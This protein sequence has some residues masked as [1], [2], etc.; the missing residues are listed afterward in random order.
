LNQP[1][2]ITGEGL[3]ADSQPKRKMTSKYNPNAN[4]FVPSQ[5]SNTT[6]VSQ[7][8]QQKSNPN[9][10]SHTNPPAAP[11]KN[12]R[13]S[14]KSRGQR[15]RE[16]KTNNINN[17]QSN[18]NFDGQHIGDEFGLNLEDEVMS[19]HFKARGRR[20]QIS[21]NH[22]LDFSLP[23]RDLESDKLN[24]SVPVRRRRRRSDN[25]EKIHLRGEE[26]VNANYR[27]IVDYRHDYKGQT[28]DPNLV[29]SNS[30]ILRVIVPKG[31][32]CPICLTEEIVAPRMIS[33]GHIFCHTCLLS[34][35]DSEGVKKKEFQKY[36]EC[37]L[38]SFSVKPE[39]IKPVLI[40]ET[41]ERFEVPQI[42]QDVVL[43]LMAKPM[44]NILPIP[45]GL[46][47]NHQ[48]IGNMPW[49][50]D[51]ELYPY[52]RIMKGGLKFI[53]NSYE[54]E[55]LAITKQ[56]EEDKLLYNDDGKYVKKALEDI[57]LRLRLYREGFGDNYTEPNPLV[58][59]MDNLS[60]NKN[61]SG[62]SDSNCYFFYQT[63]FNSPTRFFLSSLDVKVLLN[64]YGSYA[65]F[66]TTLLLKVDN[67]SY[68]HMVTENTLKKYKY[69]G[70]L[71]LGTELAFIDVNWTNMLSPEVHK[72]FAK[73]LNER[74]KKILTK[75]KKEDRAKRSFDVEQELKTLD[76][77]KTENDG[78]G[79]YDFTS[80][81]NLPFDE[82]P[83][84]PLGDEELSGEGNDEN[85]SEQSKDSSG[86]YI[87]TVW[88]T[89][90]PKGE[91]VIT[92]DDFTD[93]WNTEELIRKAKENEE[94]KQG[95]KKKGRKKK[96]VVLTSSSNRGF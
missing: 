44:D 66:P 10:S 78:W 93:D 45:F 71:P 53:V 81:E 43:R 25:D 75:M 47:L 36:K 68:G 4:A 77:Y 95:G 32:Y 21:I 3:I 94:N 83:L 67:I 6:P 86:D 8:K 55:K 28:L 82:E 70:H 48:K 73:E 57:D 24:R 84:H 63:A 29:L 35:L 23:S 54:E 87:T 12:R 89:K 38:C 64:T 41:D 13:S 49:Y 85:N 26:F 34:F 59:S 50:S 37:P 60:I 52:A 96:L 9:T 1:T 76:F 40:N 56:Y 20:G 11:S 92:E 80:Q 31:N 15:P 69:F 65:N 5:K 90:V 17:R 2:S 7:S 51:T 30:S 62:L 19:G 22:L 79:T 16:V 91:Q 58:T 14:N 18:S 27:F 39:E 33:C 46:N 61:V 72:I 88:G 74:R 42:G